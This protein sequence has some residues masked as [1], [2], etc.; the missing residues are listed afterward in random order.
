LW[1]K[2]NATGNITVCQNNTTTAASSTPYCYVN[3]ALTAIIT[4]TTYWSNWNW[5]ATGRT[6]QG[7]NILIKQNST[8]SGTIN[9]KQEC[10]TQTHFA[11]GCIQ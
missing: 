11:A 10:T 5:T 9:S 7:G 1:I 6:L 2:L 4:I 8:I 3:T